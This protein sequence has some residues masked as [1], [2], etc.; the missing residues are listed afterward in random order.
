MGDRLREAEKAYQAGYLQGYAAG[1]EA[2]A[3]VAEK[4]YTLHPA[5]GPYDDGW[6]RASEVIYREIRALSPPAPPSAPGCN[7]RNQIGVVGP[8]GGRVERCYD[9]GVISRREPAPTSA[10]TDEGEP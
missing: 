1:V 5:I 7:H 8:D 3:K 10:G 2:A 6:R 4:R 9:C